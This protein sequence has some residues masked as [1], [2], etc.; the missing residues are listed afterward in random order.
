MS[1]PL[2]DKTREEQDLE[3]ATAQLRHLVATD[4]LSPIA[5]NQ[6]IVR[7][8]RIQ[9][10]AALAAAYQRGQ[11]VG[12]LLGFDNGVSAVD[13]FGDVDETAEE[14]FARCYPAGTEKA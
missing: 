8:E 5:L 1:T 9:F 3:W 14:A 12:F 6:V 11:R 2:T 13:K 4:S 7:L 10:A